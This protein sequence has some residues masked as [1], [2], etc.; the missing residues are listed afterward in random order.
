[1]DTASIELERRDLEAE[2]S[3]AQL[4]LTGGV[5]SG[6][7]GAATIAQGEIRS[8]HAQLGLL[9][10]QLE[11]AVV[12]AP[13]AGIVMSPQLAELP[14]RVISTGENLVMIAEDSSMSLELR[15]PQNRITDLIEGNRLRFASHA[16][17]ELPG[18]S[19]LGRLAPS[20]V[21]R[22]GQSVFIAE[23]DLPEDQ[24][25][26]RP[27]MSGVVMIEVGDRPNWWLAVHRVVD[28][29]RLRFWFD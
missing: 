21:Q 20:S 19:T 24:S 8:L 13:F 7:P 28:A 2:L 27:G 1:M 17:P 6:D 11:N 25:W 9:L 16:R 18:F 26:L 22:N 4:R 15:V 3:N 23:A 29:A 12:R 10:K 5:A 14:G